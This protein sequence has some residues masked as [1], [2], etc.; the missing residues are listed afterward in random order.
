M[1]W[2]RKKVGIVKFLNFWTPE[3]FAVFYLKFKHS[4]LRVFQQKDANG[5]ANSE[6]NGS[7]LFAQTYLSENLGSLWYI[8]VISQPIYNKV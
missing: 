3:N 4:Y 7:A 1:T 5:I 8:P 2:Q 6:D